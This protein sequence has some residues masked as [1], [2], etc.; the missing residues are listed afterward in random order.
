[1]FLV[2][3]QVMA[4]QLPSEVPV[5]GVQEAHGQTSRPGCWNESRFDELK[6]VGSCRLTQF[7][8]RSVERVFGLGQETDMWDV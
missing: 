5:S 7:A 4:T 2:E 8:A 6:S 3:D 1:M